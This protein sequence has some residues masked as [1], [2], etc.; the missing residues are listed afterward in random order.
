METGFPAPVLNFHDVTPEWQYWRLEEFLHR[1]GNK[2]SLLF[3]VSSCPARK[4][5]L[6]ILEVTQISGAQLSPEPWAGTP[7]LWPCWGAWAVVSQWEHETNGHCLPIVRV[8]VTH[9][10]MLAYAGRAE[11]CGG[12]YPHT[13]LFM[14]GLESLGFSKLS[15]SRNTINIWNKHRPELESQYRCPTWNSGLMAE[16]QGPWFEPH[17]N[18]QEKFPSVLPCNK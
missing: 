17:K 3:P 16:S 18:I 13:L 7:G 9:N 10:R 2:I 12:A 11:L 15:W 6:S 14:E 5:F 8:K 1:T 4:A